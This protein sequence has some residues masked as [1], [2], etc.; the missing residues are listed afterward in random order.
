MSELSLKKERSADEV[1]AL[2]V[3]HG[4]NG[5]CSNPDLC[6]AL[7]ELRQAERDDT[8]ERIRAAFAALEGQQLGHG[9][10]SQKL[11]SILDE[12]SSAT[13]H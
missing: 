3:P 6:V 4:P 5:E 2:I 8:V 12:M 13:A 10:W 11:H 1:E 7:T 9:Y